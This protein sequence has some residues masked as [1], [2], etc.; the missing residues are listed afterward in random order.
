[1]QQHGRLLTPEDMD[2]DGGVITDEN[3]HL[4]E[5]EPVA[6]FKKGVV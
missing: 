1:M 5:Q 3:G 4:N 6:G 2:K